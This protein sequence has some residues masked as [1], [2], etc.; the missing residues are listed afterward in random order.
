MSKPYTKWTS[1]DGDVR[2]VIHDSPIELTSTRGGYDLDNTGL[3]QYDYQ[4][5]IHLKSTE[6]LALLLALADIHGYGLVEKE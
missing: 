5:G 3:S 4:T 1:D 6:A 2:V